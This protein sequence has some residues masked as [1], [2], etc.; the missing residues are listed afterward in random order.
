MTEFKGQSRP[1]FG[2]DIWAA[3]R[4]EPCMKPMVMGSVLPPY[5]TA[6]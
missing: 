1:A 6:S 4:K 3:D 5:D 2:R